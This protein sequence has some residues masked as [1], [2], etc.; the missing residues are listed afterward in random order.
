MLCIVVVNEHEWILSYSNSGESAC[1][2]GPLNV[3]REKGWL[4]KGS[5]PHKALRDI[6]MNKRLLQKIPYYL[7]PEKFNTII[8]NIFFLQVHIKKT[9]RTVS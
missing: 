6:V 2:Q 3:D 1:K 9:R 7:K 4:K 5:A 8:V